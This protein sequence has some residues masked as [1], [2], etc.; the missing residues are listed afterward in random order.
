MS[1]F[2]FSS[3]RRHTR[4]NCDWSSD[5]CSSDLSTECNFSGKTLIWHSPVGVHIYDS[6]DRHTGPIENEG[7]E[8]G[9]PGV[10]YEIIGHDKFIFLPID[11]GETYNIIA[12]GLATG[13][14]DLLISQNNNGTIES[15]T[16]FNDVPIGESG[17]VNFNVSNSSPDSNIN[18][19]YY[20]NDVVQNVPEI[21][22]AH[23]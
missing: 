15:T 10:D 7:I 22:R 18:V 9:V 3:R 17:D 1:S 14:F 20:G 5:V 13:S 11:T 12:E 23:V 6:Q 8:Y 4:W 16:V 2:F 21:G 19:D